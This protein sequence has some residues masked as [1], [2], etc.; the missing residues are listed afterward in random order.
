MEEEA[1]RKVELRL[2]MGTAVD[3]DV[4][5]EDV[6]GGRVERNETIWFQLSSFFSWSG[7]FDAAS[8]SRACARS[9]AVRLQGGRRMDDMSGEGNAD[10]MEQ[11]RETTTTTRSHMPCTLGCQAD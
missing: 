3:V 11:K 4:D 9:S 6:E 1:G 5:V 7:G 10:Q 2:V 8:L